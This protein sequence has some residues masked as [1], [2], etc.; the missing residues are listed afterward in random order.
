MVNVFGS[1]GSAFG[2]AVSTQRFFVEHNGPQTL[3]VA[4][5]APL[6]G[7]WPVVGPMRFG[8]HLEGFGLGRHNPT[9]FGWASRVL[10]IAAKQDGNYR[11]S[12]NSDF[13][14]GSLSSNLV[15]SSANHLLSWFTK[16]AYVSYASV[17]SRLPRSSWI[18]HPDASSDMLTKRH[19][20]Y[21]ILSHGPPLSIDSV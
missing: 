3:P 20:S 15:D 9:R 5:V 14:R 18:R 12:E 21:R 4:S 2:C 8:T 10:E 17:S 6:M 13:G 7:G 19:T 1:D 16:A 11:S